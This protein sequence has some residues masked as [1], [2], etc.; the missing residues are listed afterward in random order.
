[1][2]VRRLGLEDLRG[3]TIEEVLFDVVKRGEALSVR[4]PEG[5]VVL[6]APSP[7]LRPLPELDG[8]VRDGWKEAIYG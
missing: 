8:Y 2:T 4:L 6:I 3:S 7:D 1:M 5:E